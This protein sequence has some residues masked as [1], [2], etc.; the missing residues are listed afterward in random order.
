MGLYLCI[1]DHSDMEIE[2]VEV[3]SYEDFG[4]FTNA[5]VQ[6][7]E[8]GK[9]GSKYPLLTLH[10]DCD[11]CWSSDECV[12]LA[13]EFCE[14]KEHF[15]RESSIPFNSEWQQNTAKTIGLEPKNLCDCFIDVDGEGLLDRLIDLCQTA[16]ENGFPVYFQ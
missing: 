6:H 9:T 15:Q 3:G 12:K 13:E 10:S 2:G 16:S 11:G 7:L 5:V 4:W 8:G 1:F 14:I